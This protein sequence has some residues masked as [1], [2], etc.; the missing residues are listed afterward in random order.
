M[1]SLSELG[2]IDPQFG[3]MPAL[4]VKHS[5]E[6]L[7]E[8]A[9]R[10]PG[11]KEMISDYLS[12]SLPVNIVGYLERAAGS[13]AQY[14]ERLLSNRL[15]PMAAA[16][17]TEIARRL[18]YDYKDHGFAI[19]AREAATIFGGSMV[20][21]NTPHYDIANQIYEELDLMGFV[22]RWKLNRNLAFVGGLSGGCYVYSS[23]ESTQPS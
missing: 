4:A 18:V 12:K 9:S 13:A 3:G 17:N 7:A 21:T 19:D 15:S 2:P 20:E 14:A 8:I 10:H 5:L 23:K 6:H 11:A 16:E 22:A 1:G